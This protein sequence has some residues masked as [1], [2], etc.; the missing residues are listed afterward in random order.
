MFTRHN[1]TE[2]GGRQ[3]EGNEI[4]SR[5][6]PNKGVPGIHLASKG[7]EYQEFFRILKLRPAYL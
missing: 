7:N 3:N 1:I 6:Y 4:K 5:L 2:T